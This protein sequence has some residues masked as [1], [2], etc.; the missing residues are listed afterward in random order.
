MAS[1]YVKEDRSQE[2]YLCTVFHF[3]KVE[4]NYITNIG[5][6]TLQIIKIRK[7]RSITG[8][9]F[10]H[11]ISFCKRRIQFQKHVLIIYIILS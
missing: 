4:L 1:K 2:H 10:M 9:L 6:I 5:K 8:A 3:T 7:R 11:Y